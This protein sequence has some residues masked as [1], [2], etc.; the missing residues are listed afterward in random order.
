MLL[1]CCYGMFCLCGLFDH[2]LSSHLSIYSPVSFVRVAVLGC[3]VV[4]VF[5]LF[6]LLQESACMQ[7]RE[8]VRV[9]FLSLKLPSSTRLR[10]TIRSWFFQYH[11]HRIFV[12]HW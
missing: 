7:E 1:F 12:G 4:V 10:C 3:S 2:F 6:F 8:C 5:V 9:R 11:R